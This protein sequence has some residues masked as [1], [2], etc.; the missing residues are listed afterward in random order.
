MSY[1]VKII[2]DVHQPAT[3][4]QLSQWR[5][6]VGFSPF[7]SHGSALLNFRPVNLA[8]LESFADCYVIVKH[9][10]LVINPLLVGVIVLQTRLVQTKNVTNAE[11]Q[12]FV[13]VFILGRGYVV[14]YFMREVIQFLF[15]DP[16]ESI[17]YIQIE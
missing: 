13:I 10:W 8:N 12:T 5:R 17:F 1:S 16:I 9:F 4:F 15:G 6:A 3:V 11:Y 7:I 14:F 2:F